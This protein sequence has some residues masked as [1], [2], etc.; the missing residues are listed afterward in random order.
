MDMNLVVLIPAH[1][2]AAVIADTITAVL[3]QERPANG[4][5]VI[6]NGCTDDTA[7]IARKFPVTVLELPK[8]AHR[9][10]EALNLAW[11]TYADAAD[12]V[13]CLDADTSLPPY[14]LGAW[15]KE[16]E[17]NWAL[18]GAAAKFTVRGTSV[19]ARLQRSEYA[20]WTD[21]LLRR[22]VATVLSG[23]A[24]MFRNDALRA[25]AEG[26]EGPWSYKS[27]VEDFDLTYRLRRLHFDCYVSPTVRAYTD[28]MPSLRA[29]WGQRMK[30][31]VGT[32][33][34]LI[35]F[36][37]NGFTRREWAGQAGTVAAVTLRALWVVLMVTALLTGQ[38][39]FQPIWLLTL[40]PVVLNDIKQSFRIP[41][42]DK[43]DV[44]LALAF[45]PQELYSW[46]RMGWFAASWWEVISTKVLRKGSRDR[47]N[48]QY[49]AEGR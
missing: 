14:A 33:E 42:R 8:L 30:W 11:T 18:G 23:T 41:H 9:K 35:R 24:S 48:L 26:Q 2:E 15:E 13:V 32:A 5:V 25:A 21:Y 37:V 39:S 12:L 34:D 22:G 19:L 1:N 38:I 3:A 46:V 6:P 47:W 28:S 17:A 27:Q 40:V 16:F 4:V 45:L 31:Q 44:L 29:L 20:R 43:W 36:G 7:D 10:S 49:V